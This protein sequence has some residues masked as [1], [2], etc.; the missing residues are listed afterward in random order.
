MAYLLGV[1]SYL[2]VTMFKQ[3]DTTERMMANLLNSWLMVYW[4][5]L[6]FTNPFTS[7]PANSRIL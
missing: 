6:F 2:H 5:V 7:T 3:E 1:L 4:P